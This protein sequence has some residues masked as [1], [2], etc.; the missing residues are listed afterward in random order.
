MTAASPLAFIASPRGSPLALSASW[1][2]CDMGRHEYAAGDPFRL[3]WQRNN[4]DHY[5][6]RIDSDSA[7]AS[8]ANRDF[9]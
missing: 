1:Y 7:E 8:L 4:T 3:R 6:T 9:E 5:A 2:L